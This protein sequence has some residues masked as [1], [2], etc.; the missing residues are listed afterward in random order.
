MYLGTPNFQQ[1]QNIGKKSTENDIQKS[2]LFALCLTNINVESIYT[3]KNIQLGI[4][5]FAILIFCLVVITYMFFL[6]NLILLYMPILI[7]RQTTYLHYHE[8]NVWSIKNQ[9]THNLSL[10]FMNILDDIIVWA[11]SILHFEGLDMR[12]LQYEMWIFP[13]KS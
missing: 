12:N 5:A 8:T 2:N 13:N 4:P 3:C 1:F 6:V 9:T 7:Y 11:P 10:D